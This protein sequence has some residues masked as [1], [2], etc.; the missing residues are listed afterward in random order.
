MPATLTIAA[1]FNGPPGSG[2]GGYVCGQLARFIDGSARVRLKVPP[3]L[4]RPLSVEDDGPGVRLTDRGR[5]VA[6]ARP[7]AF[8]LDI[9]APPSPDEARVASRAYRGFVRH[10]FPSC[11]VCGPARAEGEGLRIFAGPLPGRDMVAAPWTPHP[12]LASKDGL[13]RSEFLWA[14]LDCPGAF[15]FPEPDRGVA[16]LGEMMAH[17]TAAVPAD[18]ACVVIGWPLGRKG[19]MHY[20]ATALFDDR[21][22]CCAMARATWL[23]V[24][25]WPP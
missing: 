16:L 13:V 15:A 22:N 14:A 2:N 1:Q 3:P 6:T 21:G 10:W 23:E 11:F 8:D 9:P 19:R 7:E 20:S 17:L 24:A 18:S 5:T 12:S 4:E 25:A